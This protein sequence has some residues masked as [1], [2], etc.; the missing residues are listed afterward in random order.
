[1]K[2]GIFCLTCRDDIKNIRLTNTFK[3]TLHGDKCPLAD[4]LYQALQRSFDFPDYFGHNMDALY[5]C[6]LDL[7][8]IVEPNVALIL[9]D[10][11]EL[12][13]EEIDGDLLVENFLCLLDDVV[14]SWNRLDSPLIEAKNFNVYFLESEKAKTRMRDLGISFEEV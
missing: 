9:E 3:V 11:D 4:N 2:S 12:L 8:W 10:F 5:D 1:M 7:E 14:Q 6:L 13:D